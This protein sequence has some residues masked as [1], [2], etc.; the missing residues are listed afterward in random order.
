MKNRILIYCLLNIMLCLTACEKFLDTKPTDFLA[1]KLF[2]DS[3]SQLQSALR[4]VY[5]PLGYAR[6]YQD[7]WWHRLAG[8]TDENWSNAGYSRI[9][10]NSLNASDGAVRD[11]WQNCYLGIER[12][13]ILLENYTKPNMNE[14][15]RLEIKGQALFLRAYYYFL[16]VS[17]WGDVPL[18]LTSTSTANDAKLL[19]TPKEKVYE[20]ILKDMQEAQAI[21]P[22][23]SSLGYNGQVSK[24]AAQAILARVC[25]KMAGNPLNDQ[26]KYQ[27]AKNWCD[28]VINSG[29]HALAKN[30]AQ[31]FINHSQDKYDIKECLWEVEFYGN[32]IGNSFSESSRLGYNTG[33][34]CSSINVG[35]S[36]ATIRPTAKLFSLY[37]DSTD[38]RLNWNI[39]PWRY[40][41]TSNPTS[42][43]N[44]T[45]TQI[46][47]RF[48]GKWYREKEIISPKS[49]IQAPTNFPIIRYADVLL[50]WAEADNEINGPT[51]GAIDMVNQVRRRG[52][53]KLEG[54]IIRS[55]NLVGTGGS[56]YTSI[57]TVTITGG[58][59]AGARA[60]AT[61]SAGRV[62][63]ITI[64]NRG[65]SYTSVPTVTI[66]GGG[67]I[68]ATAI[69]VLSNDSDADLSPAQV[70]NQGSLR[71][72]IRDERARELCYE[73]LRKPDLIRWG[74]YISTMKDFAAFVRSTA[75]AN[76]QAIAR[77]G[78]DLSE[79][80]ILFPIPA[81]EI[82]LNPLLTQNPGW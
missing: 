13:N 80:N 36:I 67:G 60:T 34:S 28:S 75:P 55:I 59:G 53:G 11:A 72:A 66:N 58:G 79:R 39:C 48:S 77:V 21:L 15:K 61:I 62:T 47:D 6:M 76:F 70:V 68:G 12:A 32:G 29:E 81:S 30:Y 42:K 27:E 57:P 37:A 82:A 65:S 43:I 46:W 52:Y 69:A 50:M 26:S 14:S 56:G 73:A 33:P 63:A 5:D 8:S 78:D 24:T 4:G 7:G 16:L 64:T 54:Q 74:I 22:K 71:Q 3:E 51:S 18:K 19:R 31:I 25:L 2:F 17:N 38:F 10:T 20:Q 23:V 44:F 45:P 1:P 35:F 41:S 9:E 49:Q 40:N